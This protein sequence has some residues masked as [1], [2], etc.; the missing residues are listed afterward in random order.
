MPVH[1]DRCKKS[2]IHMLS[3]AASSEASGSNQLSK[4]APMNPAAATG[5]SSIT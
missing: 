5:S 4:T 2:V 1:R 3:G